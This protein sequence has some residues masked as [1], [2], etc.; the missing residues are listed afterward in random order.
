MQ[1]RFSA[2]QCTH[3]RTGAGQGRGREV[4]GYM[5]CLLRVSWWRLREQA[6]YVP[7]ELPPSPPRGCRHTIMLLAKRLSQNHFCVQRIGLLVRSAL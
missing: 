5:S 4:L 1:G 6:A 7:R 3:A 2:Q